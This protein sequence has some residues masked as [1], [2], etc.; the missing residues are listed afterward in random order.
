MAKGD[1]VVVDA[2]KKMWKG[3]TLNHPPPS[4]DRV[5]DSLISYHG[6]YK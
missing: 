5:I 2:S 1:D 6:E 4:T 3:K